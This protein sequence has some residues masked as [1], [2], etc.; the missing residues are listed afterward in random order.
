MED[1]AKQAGVSR[2][3]V[4]LV[5]QDA[6]N[7]SETRRNAVMEAAAALGYRPNRLARNL[8]RGRSMTIGVVIDDLHPFFSGVVE[9]I[10]ERVESSG[11][12]TLI[13][14]GARDADRAARA[15]A[16]FDGLQVDGAIAVGARGEISALIRATP[17]IPL[18]LVA[19]EAPA[20]EIDTVNSD[21]SVGSAHAVEHLVS[22]GHERIVHVDGGLGASAAG[23]R[24]GYAAAMKRLGL[25]AQI[26]VIPGDFTH[27]AGQ[28]AAIQIAERA[29]RPTAVFAAND[30]NALGMISEFN[31]LG[32]SV[33]DEVSIV[34]Y[35]DTAYSGLGAQGLTT[36]HQPVYEMG[37]RAAEVLLERL[38]G[39]RTESTFEVLA[40]WLVTRG[41]TA[42]VRSGS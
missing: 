38:A 26:D 31:R 39:T 23:R 36:V 25:A 17:A 37:T 4:S 6:P 42:P 3:L 2:S 21:E 7:V 14:N 18:V 5:F 19:F 35:D 10:E 28:K 27:D 8:A 11:Y 9:G 40:P 33:P 16:T 34:G 13:A 20:P 22:L 30:L 24:A 15:L 41:T 1:V 12:H 32:I 29:Q